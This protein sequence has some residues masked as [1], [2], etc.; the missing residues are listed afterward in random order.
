MVG[1][2]EFK[3]TRGESNRATAAEPAGSAFHRE[4]ENA[5]TSIVNHLKR[6]TPNDLNE[7]LIDFRDQILTLE[8]RGGKDV[9]AN[10]R[11]FLQALTSQ[12]DDLDASNKL[13]GL[14]FP[15]F[16]LTQDGEKLTLSAEIKEKNGTVDSSS[17]HF[18]WTSFTKK[19]HHSGNTAELTGSDF[20]QALQPKPDQSTVPEAPPAVPPEAAQGPGILT[21]NVQ[22]QQVNIS[23][24]ESHYPAPKMVYDGNVQAQQH[25]R[26]TGH[27]SV[28]GDVINITAH[29]ASLPGTA[30]WINVTG[31]NLYHS[32]YGFFEK[33]D[34]NE[35][36]PARRPAGPTEIFHLLQVSR[37]D[38]A[39][40]PGRP[41]VVRPS[42]ARWDVELQANPE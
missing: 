41:V 27:V 21:G 13:N 33:V 38:A 34:N 25:I 22:D 6:G 4:L 23:T 30:T 29:D 20:M 14:G 1:M 24:G 8:K 40:A 9:V 18:D 3:D 39:N 15:K 7:A 16:H 35:A 5:A 28:P 19:H 36:N 31:S 11:D 26:Y 10:E 42:G 37:Y 17:Y 32:A 12:R 2:T